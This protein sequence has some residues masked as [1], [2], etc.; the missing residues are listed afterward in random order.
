MYNFEFVSTFQALRHLDAAAPKEHIL[1][2]P[3]TDR[4][5]AKHF[6]AEMISALM[7]RVVKVHYQEAYARFGLGKRL[8]V[9]LGK[10]FRVGRTMKNQ[11]LGNIKVYRRILDDR[12]EIHER[13]NSVRYL[14]ITG[15]EKR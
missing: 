7:R 12:L 10:A 8:E 5:C 3:P 13:Q 6:S 14:I 1:T 11:N 9:Q 4:F 2:D 15:L